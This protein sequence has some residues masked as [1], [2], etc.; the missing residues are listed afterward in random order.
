MAQLQAQFLLDEAGLQQ[1]GNLPLETA[2]SILPGELPAAVAPF[3][4]LWP[5]DCS[6]PCTLMAHASQ[7][8]ISTA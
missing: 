4:Q 5:L 1:P 2:C 3:L 8:L 6:A 7:N